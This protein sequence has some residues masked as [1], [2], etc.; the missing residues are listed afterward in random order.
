MKRL[1]ILSSSALLV[2]SIYFLTPQTY[3]PS[4]QIHQIYTSSAGGVVE[5]A[6]DTPFGTY[7]GTCATS[8]H[9][10]RHLDTG[11]EQS[12]QQ[13]CSSQV[14][15]SL[16]YITLLFSQERCFFST[17]RGTWRLPSWHHSCAVV[18]PVCLTCCSSARHQQHLQ[19][20]AMQH[21]RA[22][23]VRWIRWRPPSRQQLRG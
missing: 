5:D 23:M 12:I 15:T 1:F 2:F 13:M 8:H 16:T 6:H 10:S 14:Q 20:R 4:L 19:T 9:S 22:V 18:D 7:Q 3:L 11:L 21:S 17:Q